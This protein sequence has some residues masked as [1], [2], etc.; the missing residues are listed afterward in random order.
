MATA[1]AYH[2][3]QQEADI[4]YIHVTW[5]DPHSPSVQVQAFASGLQ[6]P[7]AGPAT[8]PKNQL[9]HLSDP[10]LEPDS[11][12]VSFGAPYQSSLISLLA[13]KAGK[14]KTILENNKISFK[15]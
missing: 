11:H 8:V 7:S 4:I 2:T 5:Q 6:A 1:A 9:V 15:K 13:L 12:D 14:K 10:E 3:E